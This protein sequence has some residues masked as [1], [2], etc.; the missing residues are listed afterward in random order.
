[1]GRLERG[2]AELMESEDRPRLAR[3]RIARKTINILVAEVELSLVNSR[4]LQ[5]DRAMSTPLHWPDSGF[6]TPRRVS[7]GRAPYQ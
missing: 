2:Q 5:S 7:A 3:E 6:E 1:M 4:I